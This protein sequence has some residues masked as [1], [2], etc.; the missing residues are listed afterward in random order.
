MLRATGKWGGQLHLTLTSFAGAAGCPDSWGNVHGSSL[1]SA[2]QQ[3]ACHGE[4]CSP[5]EPG[6]R[7]IALVESTPHELAAAARRHQLEMAATAAAAAAAAQPS[8]QF[9]DGGGGGGFGFGGGGGGW[10][11]GEIWALDAGSGGLGSISAIYSPGPSQTLR[12]E[13]PTR[14]AHS[15]ESLFR[16]SEPT[17][18]LQ[19][20]IWQRACRR[21]R[22][23]GRDGR[24]VNSCPHRETPLQ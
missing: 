5:M 4:G 10:S 24:P 8:S 17:S 21:L 19:S 14:V 12:S 18:W 23:T 2:A 9:G 15:S 13:F 11:G 1:V 6:H 20:Q 3:V 22:F 16:C 7:V